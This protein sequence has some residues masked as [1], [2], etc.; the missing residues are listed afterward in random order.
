MNI[1][2]SVQFKRSDINWRLELDKDIPYLAATQQN[3]EIWY[4]SSNGQKVTP[5]RNDEFGAVLKWNVYQD[6]QGRLIF[7]AP[8]TEIG[9]MQFYDCATITEILLPEG[10]TSIGYE[11]FAGCTSLEKVQIPATLNTISGGAGY[12]FNGCTKLSSFTGA[13]HSSD[14]RLL[15]FQNGTYLSVVASALYGLTSYTIENVSVEDTA[16]SNATGLQELTLGS[17]CGISSLPPKLKKLYVTESSFTW[18]GLPDMDYIPQGCEIYGQ[19]ASYGN[20]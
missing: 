17:N 11:A 18:S 13:H 7:D 2:K 8:P 6:G 20:N 10:I 15:C 4:K 12:S 3:N 9:T 1:N 16:F 14:G 5:Y 19:Y